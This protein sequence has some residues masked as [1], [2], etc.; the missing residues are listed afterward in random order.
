[1]S[2]RIAVLTLLAF[3]FVVALTA[4]GGAPSPTAA[5]PTA[6]PVT[7]PTA[8]SA[9]PTAAPTAVPATAAPTTAPTAAATGKGIKVGLVTDVGGPDDK[10][11]NATAIKG[12]QDAVKDGIASSDSKFLQSRQQTDYSKNIEE[13]IGQGYQM[14]VTVGF[15]L[16][17]D[18]AKEA[19]ANPKVNFAIVDYQYPDCAPNA[20]EG[21]DCGSA[22]E[23]PNVLGL[24]FQTDQAAFQAGYLAA[25]MS[26][27]KKVGTYGGVNIPTVSIFMVG[28]QGGV[29]YWNA[30]HNDKVQVIGWDTKK[31]DGVFTGTFTDPD[32]GKQA[33][34]SLIDEGADVIMPVAGLTGNGAFTAAK[35]KSILAIGVDTDQCVSVP[36][37][38]PVLLTS[39]RKNM[40]VAV[41]DAIKA[42]ADGTFKGGTYKGTLSNNGVSLAPFNQ[43]DSKIPANVKSDLDA[44]KADIIAGKIDV[45]AWAKGE[46]KLT[47]AAPVAAVKVGVV[48]DVGGP[49]DKSFNQT[50]IKGMNDAVKDG[51][52]TADSKYLQ[53]RQQ[54]DYA[55]NIEEFIGQG[56]QMIVS[57]G[58]LLGVDTAKEAKANPKVNFAIVD[59]NYPDCAPNAKEG[60]DCGSATDIPNVLGLKYHVEQPAFQ[61]GYLAASMSKTKKVGTYGGVNIPAVADFMWGFEGGV[62]YWNAKHNDKVQVLGWSTKKN[63]GVFT[64]TF[65]DPDKGKQAALSLIDEG[66]DVILPVAGLTGNGTFTAAKEKNVMAIGVDTDQCISVPDACP[67]LLT[68]V[69]KNMDVTV[70][71]AIKAVANGTFKGGTYWATLADGGVSLAPFNQFDSKIPADVK[72]DLDQIKTDIGS[73]KIDIKAWANGTA[74]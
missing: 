38:C 37:A 62:N 50:A 66:A 19:K 48:T 24:S 51:L 54:T 40:D 74:K 14:I 13:F 9:Q 56:Y 47:S 6:A 41:H 23:I 3:V 1:M 69:R 44:I 57:V 64:G 65:T 53:S 18:T 35:E 16:G 36:D 46:G 45:T 70:Y 68:S 31:S 32:K 49:D 52:A 33:A 34:L 17:V 39:V 30:K 2:K 22:T 11:F 10:S 42:A 55:K 59:Y 8:A 7:Q 67:V 12:M 28:F 72:T 61:A 73:G 71:N 63:D 5:P 4:C 20:K 27:T 60:V 25:S 26:K 43:F 58:F 21:T 29:N 15:L